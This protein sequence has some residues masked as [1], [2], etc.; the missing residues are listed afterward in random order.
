[1]EAVKM[2]SARLRVLAQLADGP[3]E[4]AGLVVLEIRRP[5]MEA[6]QSSGM[7][8]YRP[9]GKPPTY[10]ITAAGREVLAQ[11]QI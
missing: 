10:A 8:K 3:I 11:Q 7:A 2:T 6:L 9:Y 4:N 5:I 1:V